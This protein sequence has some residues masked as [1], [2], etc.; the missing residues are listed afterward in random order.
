M[1]NNANNESID[2]FAKTIG[3]YP[4]GNLRSK[5]EKTRQDAIRVLEAMIEEMD[6]RDGDS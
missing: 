1:P 4:S 3:P 5:E 2:D 6:R